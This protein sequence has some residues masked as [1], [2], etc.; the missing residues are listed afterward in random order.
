VGF[1]V[2]GAWSVKYAAV[3]QGKAIIFSDNERG[4]CTH[5][6]CVGFETRNEGRNFE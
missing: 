2:R 6:F 5:F 1:V 4:L 3:I